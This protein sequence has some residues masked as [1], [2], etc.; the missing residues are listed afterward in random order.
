M[1]RT[2]QAS[3][4]RRLAE[5]TRRQVQAGREA[6]NVR[7][8]P[9]PNSRLSQAPGAQQAP[10]RGKA[11]LGWFSSIGENFKRGAQTLRRSGGR[12]TEADETWYEPP[13]DDGEE[14]DFGIH[15]STGS[16]LRRP[17]PGGR[18]TQ[19][20]Q[21]A[22][23]QTE[24]TLDSEGAWSQPF[25]GNPFLAPDQARSRPEQAMS[26]PAS[27]LGQSSSP[28]PGNATEAPPPGPA[29]PPSAG[30]RA[31]LPHSHESSDT[32]GD[33]ARGGAP[34]TRQQPPAVDTAHGLHGT[35]NPLSRKTTAPVDEP[36]PMSTQ[37]STSTPGQHKEEG[38][39][40]QGPPTPEP[41]VAARRSRPERG[42][43]GRRRRPQGPRQTADD[44]FADDQIDSDY[45]DAGAP[46]RPAARSDLHDQLS[47][48]SDDFERLQAKVED[49]EATAETV[50]QE[51]FANLQ[52]LEAAVERRED[53]VMA[54]VGQT[55]DLGR[56]RGEL[57]AEVREEVA[58]TVESQ[59]KLIMDLAM[60]QVSQL[61]HQVRRAE[62]ETLLS[63]LADIRGSLVHFLL[64][65][66]VK[67]ASAAQP[68]VEPVWST[69][70]GLLGWI[71]TSVGVSNEQCGR[72]WRCCC[73]RTRA[74]DLQGAPTPGAAPAPHPMAAGQLEQTGRLHSHH[75]EAQGRQYADMGQAPRQVAGWDAGPATP[76]Q[77]PMPRRVGHRYT[78]PPPP[79]ALPPA[80]HDPRGH[81]YVPGPEPG[82][83]PPALP[84]AGGLP[85]AYPPVARDRRLE[86]SPPLRS[87]AWQ[88]Q[89]AARAADGAI[90]ARQR[91]DARPGRSFRQAPTAHRH[92]SSSPPFDTSS[93]ERGSQGRYSAQYGYD[94]RPEFSLPAAQ[95]PRG[96][97]TSMLHREPRQDAWEGAGAYRRLPRGAGSMRD[98][99]QAYAPRR[100]VAGRG[101]GPDARSTSSYDS[102]AHDFDGLE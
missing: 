11:I 89:E 53:M 47:V 74:E 75:T 15:R 98:V 17:P 81:W 51:L 36:T 35:V 59:G 85:T 34:P 26:A 70:Y 27:G 73:S 31:P 61:A 45:S 56:L 64:T 6:G 9:N 67:V 10:S 13:P 46:V 32:D 24:H 93:A 18:P 7:R 94:G 29:P 22:T 99:G 30:F 49:L 42:H 14:A 88:G 65:G 83:Y 43:S 92:A 102:R 63:T 95:L 77:A 100:D 39:A 25:R 76:D 71:G 2:E 60:G 54:H 4:R 91:H 5:Q 87:R 86:R 90:S 97:D 72:L 58:A 23:H 8:V 19:P 28:Q 55:A 16:T 41:P 68:A 38:P 57:L 84:G 1:S 69:L 12:P 62:D 48:L 37:G 101:G 50:E 33:G 40:P 79:D 52:Y 96:G 21:E 66:T 78:P 20:T 3:P 80:T 82:R 44:Y